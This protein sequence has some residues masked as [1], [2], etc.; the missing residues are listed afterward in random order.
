[1]SEF[2]SNY[3]ISNSAKG[4][5]CHD[6]CRMIIFSTVQEENYVRFSVEGS[7]F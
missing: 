4:K 1:M 7:Y 3:H 5:L 2:Q 6:Y